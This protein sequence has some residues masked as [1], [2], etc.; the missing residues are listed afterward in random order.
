MFFS[1]YQNIGEIESVLRIHATDES[2]NT[3]KDKFTSAKALSEQN[4]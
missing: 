2:F 4:G 1:K 3:V